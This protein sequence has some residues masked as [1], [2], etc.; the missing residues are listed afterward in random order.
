MFTYINTV[1]NN[2]YEWTQKGKTLD[3]RTCVKNRKRERCKDKITFIKD[4]FL[5]CFY[6]FFVVLAVEVSPFSDTKDI[7]M[8]KCYPNIHIICHIQIDAKHNC[9][10]FL[11]LRNAYLYC[12][13]TWL[14]WLPKL[15]V[16]SWKSTSP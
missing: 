4:I 5:L 10:F 7:W 15:Y 11:M 1:F 16:L 3:T 12:T 13:C 2:N 9:L 8:D 6:A 14:F